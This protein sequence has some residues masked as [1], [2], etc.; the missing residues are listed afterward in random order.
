MALYNPIRL[1]LNPAK[2]SSENMD[3]YYTLPF[4]HFQVTTR[5]SK[6]VDLPPPPKKARAPAPAP[7]HK[8][9]RPSVP[10]A[11][12]ALATPAP[13]DNAPIAEV[14][15]EEEES[16]ATTVEH[17]SY[18]QVCGKLVCPCPGEGWGLSFDWLTCWLVNLR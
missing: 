8:P 9:A 4:F 15:E 13:P 18:Q 11:N 7:R 10:W 1:H 5:V 17:D 2:T 6:P 16:G 3:I 12:G 14:D